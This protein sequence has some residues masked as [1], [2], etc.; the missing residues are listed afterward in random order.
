[1]AW[2]PTRQERILLW[3]AA[4]V[5]KT[6]AELGIMK[7]AAL[8]RTDNHFWIIDNDNQMEASGLVEGGEFEDLVD[9]STI[10]VPES[11]DEYDDITNTIKTNAGPQ[12]WIFIDMLSNVYQS[13][14]DWWVENVYGENPHTYWGA[15]RK[16]IV[17]AQQ[18]ADMKGEKGGHE[19]QFGGTSGVDWQYIG[20]QYRAW[21]KRLSIFAPCHV[22]AVC[23]EQEIEERYDRDGTRRAQFAQT[24]AVA[25]KG[26]KDAV[27][28][29]HTTMRMQRRVG[30]DGKSVAGRT[31]TMHKDRGRTEK[32]A[33]LGGRGKT[34]ELSEGPKFAQDYLMKVGGWRMVG[35]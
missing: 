34:I 2:K 19:R 7:F 27:H 12:D 15:V 6:Y 17:E 22:M 1:M 33:E 4:G 11:F 28:R 29:F 8:T 32:W 20:K 18:Q 10:W 13:L 31:I 26:E 21:E 9:R 25:P 30:R 14:P 5:G 23:G 16:E 35:G 3:A 24:S